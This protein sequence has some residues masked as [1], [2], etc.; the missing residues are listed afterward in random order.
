[1]ILHELVVC[2][3]G[4][5][6]PS[7]NDGFQGGVKRKLDQMLQESIKIFLSSKF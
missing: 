6:Y 4:H 2:V 7:E 1:M 5:I 3:E